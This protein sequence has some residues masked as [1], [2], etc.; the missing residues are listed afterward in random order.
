MKS[1][2]TLKKELLKD[3]KAREEYERLKP[4]YQM[5]SEIIEARKRKGFT[6]EDL[7]K[8]IGTKQ[9]AIARI[10]SGN[11][12]PTVNFLEKVAS[13]LDSNLTIQFK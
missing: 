13:A 4:R 7:A 12:N 2:K 9:S 10:E 5:I 6:Q 8:K 11:A 3:K 1:W